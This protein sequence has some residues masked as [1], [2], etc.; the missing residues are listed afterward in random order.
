MSRYRLRKKEEAEVATESLN[1]IMFFLMLFFLIVSTLVN[2][3]V[4]KL[5]LP[6]SKSSSS[7]AKQ[8]ITLT[9]TQDK[10]IFLNSEK[11]SIAVENLE[12]RLLQLAELKDNP[13]IV[14]RL[15][16]SLTVQDL[17]N[18]LQIGNKLKIKMVM[19]TKEAK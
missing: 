4:I 16:Q 15:D 5:S 10:L 18:V 9:I 17:V 11:Q 14:L 12:N 8:P 19:A 2:P 7:M 13:T 1:D 6:N 3:N